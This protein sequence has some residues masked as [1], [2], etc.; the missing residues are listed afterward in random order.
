MSLTV[1]LALCIL[2]LDCMIYVF[3]QWTYGDKRNALAREL[4]AHKKALKEASRRPFRRTYKAFPRPHMALAS[5]NK[6]TTNLR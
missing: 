4:A 1:F 6:L 5:G 3:F 2:G